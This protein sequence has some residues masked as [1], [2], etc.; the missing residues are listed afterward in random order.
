MKITSALV[1]ALSG[2]AAAE[3][4]VS[5]LLF[6]VDYD[7]D[8]VASIVTSDATATT[9]SLTCPT[10]VESHDCDVL[11][12]IT[13]VADSKDDSYTWWGSARDG[14]TATWACGPSGTEEGVCK[15]TS[16]GTDVGL[17]AYFT[18]Y[19]SATVTGGSAAATASSRQST[20]TASASE[21]ASGSESAATSTP[22][23]TGSEEETPTGGVLRVT[24][25]AGLILG[26]AAVAVMGAVL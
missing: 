14:F 15:K 16:E 10:D 5:L 22:T 21:G 20:S 13:A 1:P 25:A 2:L 18:N 12:G 11:N 26:G 19:L 17:T 4:T 8:H 9:Y 3:S 6:A 24:A 7:Q 23:P